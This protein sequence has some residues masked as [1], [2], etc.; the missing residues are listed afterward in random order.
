[1]PSINSVDPL[2]APSLYL[3]LVFLTIVINKGEELY[4]P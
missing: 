3:I 1:M 2:I 4:S